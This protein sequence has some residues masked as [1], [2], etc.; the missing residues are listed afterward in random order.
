M[1]IECDSA[2]FPTRSRSGKEYGS[3]ASISG[4]GI[5]FTIYEKAI[6]LSCSSAEE[7]RARKRAISDVQRNMRGIIGGNSIMTRKNSSASY[8]DWIV[9]EFRRRPALAP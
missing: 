6:R 7:T 9:G 2:T 3:C 8:D 4:R 1:S 5:A